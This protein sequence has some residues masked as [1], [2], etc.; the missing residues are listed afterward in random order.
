MI[1]FKRQDYVCRPLMELLWWITYCYGE[2]ALLILLFLCY[3]QYRVG[4]WPSGKAPGFGPGIRGFESLRPSQLK[5]LEPC[6][7]TFLINYGYGGI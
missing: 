3:N 4:T 1:N 2:A 7:L 6:V 5:K